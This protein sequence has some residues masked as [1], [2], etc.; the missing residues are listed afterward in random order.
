ML[1]VEVGVNDK[2]EVVLQFSQPLKWV[3]F[4]PKQARLVAIDLLRFAEEAEEKR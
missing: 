1:G 2:R 4:K 3:G